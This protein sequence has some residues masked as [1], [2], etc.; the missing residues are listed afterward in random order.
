MFL[1]ASASGIARS[2]TTLT[3]GGLGGRDGCDTRGP[4]GQVRLRHATVPASPGVFTSLIHRAP[5]A[6]VPRWVAARASPG[7]GG[8]GGGSSYGGNLSMDSSRDDSGARNDYWRG[9]AGGSEGRRGRGGGGRGSHARAEGDRGASPSRGAR[10]RGR[11]DGKSNHGD[12]RRGPDAPRG[13]RA[14]GGAGPGSGAHAVPDRRHGGRG[15]SGGRGESRGGR[16]SAPE[17]ASPA[18]AARKNKMRQHTGTLSSCESCDA[19]LEYA[20]AHARTFTAVNFSTA[21]HKLGKLNRSARGRRTQLAAR[22]VDDPRFQ[23]LEAA[24]D[25]SLERFAAPDAASHPSAAEFHGVWGA[26]EVSCALWGFAN[27]GRTAESFANGGGGGGEA[28]ADGV[29]SRRAAARGSAHCPNLFANLLRKVAAFD[30]AAFSSQNLS[31]AAWALAKM[32]SGPGALAAPSSGH[33]APVAADADGNARA[34][35]ADD[36]TLDVLVVRATD[37][38]E[39]AI[40]DRLARPPRGDAFI[41]QGVSNSMWA[42]AVLKKHELQRNCGDVSSSD[43]AENGIAPATARAFSAYITSPG[44]AD[45]FKSMELSNVIWAISTMRCRV[46]RETGEALD[47]AVVRACD[48]APHMFST[49]SVANILWAAGNTPEL[50]PLSTEALDRLAKMTYAKFPEFTTQGLANT[51]WGF[52]AANYHPGEGLFK[53]IRRAWVEKGDGYSVIELNNMLWAMHTLKASPG[54]KVFASVHARVA[55]LCAADADAPRGESAELT[56]N[57]AANFMYHMAQYEELPSPATMV[58]LEEAML[59]KIAARGGE[60]VRRTDGDSSDDASSEAREKASALRT[61]RR[62]GRR[63]ERADPREPG[64]GCFVSAS[65]TRR[66]ADAIQPHLVS[67][68]LWA[69]SVLRYKPGAALLRAFDDLVEARVEDYTD[70]S[71]SMTVFAYANLA[72]EPK[73]GTLEKLLR[74]CET[75]VTSGG[76][77]AQGLANSFWGWAVLGASSPR[78]VAAYARRFAEADDEDRPGDA[79]SDAKNALSR[80]DLVQIYQ[81]SL[82]FAHCEV[83]RDGELECDVTEPNALEAGSNPGSN[84]LRGALLERAKAVWEQTST[85]RVTISSLHREVSE[86]LT[87]MAV[88]HEIEAVADDNFSLDIALRGRAVAIEV[89]GPSHFFAN[90]PC[91]YMGADKL[92]EK[93]LRAKGWTVRALLIVFF[94]R[95]NESPREDARAT[96]RFFRFCGLVFPYGEGGGFVSFR[97]TEDRLDDTTR[98]SLSVPSLTAN[99]R[100]AVNNRTS[101]AERSSDGFG[102]FSLF[103]SVPR[104]APRTRASFFARNHSYAPDTSSSALTFETRPFFSRD[105]R[106]DDTRV[107]KIVVLRLSTQVLRVPWHEWREDFGMDERCDYLANL[108][109]RGAGLTVRDASVVPGGVR[110]GGRTFHPERG[111]VGFRDGASFRDDAS[112]RV[113]DAADSRRFDDSS[114]AASETYSGDDGMS[115]YVRRVVADPG[116]NV[117]VNRVGAVIVE[118]NTF[119][120][121]ARAL[122]DS[123]Y[124]PRMYSKDKP[125]PSAGYEDGGYDPRRSEADEILRRAERSARLNEVKSAG[126]VRS[127]AEVAPYGISLEPGAGS[128]AK[129]GRDGAPR[130]KGRGGRTDAPGPL[131]AEKAEKS[132]PAPNRAASVRRRA[133]PR[134]SAQTSR[135]AGTAGA[136]RRRR[137][138]VSV[139]KAASSRFAG[140]ARA[141]EKDAASP[142]T[143]PSTPPS[144]PSSTASN[145]RESSTTSSASL[146][147]SADSAR[148]PDARDAPVSALRG[149]GSKSAARLKAIG[150][151]SVGDLA[152]LSDARCAEATAKKNDAEKNGGASVRGLRDKARR[153]LG[154]EA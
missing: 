31:N 143:K 106:F 154:E 58:R 80:V 87:R 75:R 28:R 150:V 32:H 4:A 132:R 114:A 55:A 6:A 49:Q 5:R 129:R 24:L 7:G 73:R 140:A 108:L 139:P 26:R 78:L 71:L 56:F 82:A 57:H 27:C 116:S 44:A 42:L 10:G 141:A 20:E 54:R 102:F 88:P 53:E 45:G 133:A 63:D 25:A 83:S 144:T 145:A 18:A 48:D 37:A 126:D 117:R 146:W 38:L 13:Q 115:G 62:S 14:R 39:G 109:Y 65:A 93:V 136:I 30:G 113:F 86:T 70:Q 84:P 69:F 90:K 101:K 64:E 72:F 95:R 149:V 60:T 85:G 23:K 125:S 19:V 137:V 110:M 104:R 96:R 135:A 66:A 76:F 36:E 29:G 103:D 111:G 8:G 142:S 127:F 118:D 3:L 134:A 22:L 99:T 100:E 21:I 35:A 68:T 81:A 128:A 17:P 105:V 152:A 123:E 43:I 15:G 131:G 97:P 52:A 120:A 11:G 16:K 91:E 67:N 2:F 107:D 41:P 119:D 9:G 46:S 138:R 12:G 147:S 1:L 122:R 34:S 151:E 98:D 33:A 50:V 121:D 89:D 51:L 74:E 124:V 47:A 79:G 92:R 153:A 61:R 148:A 40:R 59:R 94:A 130:R 77:T 112:S